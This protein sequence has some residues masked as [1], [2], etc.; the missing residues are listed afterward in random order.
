MTG[1]GGASGGPRGQREKPGAGDRAGAGVHRKQAGPVRKT[2]E[3]VVSGA[4]G[5]GLVG[6]LLVLLHAGGMPPAVAAESPPALA[7]PPIGTSRTASASPIGV[8]GGTDGG[9]SGS[10]GGAAGTGGDHPGAGAAAQ[11]STAVPLV[12]SSSP[13]AVASS[14]A[15]SQSASPDPSGSPSHSAT[16]TPSPSASSAGL[17]GGAVSGVVGGLAG[18]VGQLVGGLSGGSH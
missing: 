4:A 14:A 7:H 6:G 10:V 12:P 9:G 5:M 2:V 8:L 1:V 13:V 16:P 15:P 11:V 3:V 18:L 17:L